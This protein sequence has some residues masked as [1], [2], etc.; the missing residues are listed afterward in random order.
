MPLN[1]RCATAAAAMPRSFAPASWARR[2]V[3]ALREERTG[4]KGFDDIIVLG[5]PD[6]ELAEALGASV[7][8]NGVMAIVANKPIARPLQD[9]RRARAL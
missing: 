3:K 8:R 9:R 2:Q 4:D 7:A 5:T 1:R 6:P